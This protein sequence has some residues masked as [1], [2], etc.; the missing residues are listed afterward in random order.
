MTITENGHDFGPIFS[1][2]PMTPSLLSELTGYVCTIFSVSSAFPPSVVSGVP[3]GNTAV[4]RP[5]GQSC[6]TKFHSP[7]RNPIE[8]AALPLPGGLC[9]PIRYCG[10]G[11][12]EVPSGKGWP[13]SAAQ[14]GHAV[15]PHPRARDLDGNEGI[16]C[17][18]ATNP[19]S[20]RSR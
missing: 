5:C 13:P 14:T 19:N 1:D 2:A 7:S 8:V 15:F 10:I 4:A 6:L 18:K 11:S 12:E 3:G 20:S 17:V 9:C 16:K